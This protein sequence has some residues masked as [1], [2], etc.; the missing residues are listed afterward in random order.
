MVVEAIEYSRFGNEVVLDLV[1]IDSTALDVNQVRVEVHAVGL[2]L[3][4]LYFQ[5][6][7][8]EIFL[9]LLQKLVIK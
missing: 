2:N 6:V 4:H 5:K 9:V 3:N 1:K 7:W 8:G